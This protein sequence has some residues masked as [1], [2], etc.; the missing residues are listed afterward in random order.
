M[1]FYPMQEH[2]RQ[3]ENEMFSVPVL[4]YD[5]DDPEFCEIGHY[6][7]DTGMWSHFGDFSMKLIC[8]CY[9]PDATE[10]VK[11]NKLVHV[12]HDGYQP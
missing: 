11:N 2:P 12:L 8:W 3:K 1:K 7:F 6:D 10:F 9:L 4:V 5:M